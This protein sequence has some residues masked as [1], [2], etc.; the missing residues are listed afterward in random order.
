MKKFGEY[1]R[2]NTKNIINFEKILT[3]FMLPLTKEELD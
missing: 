3:F 2:E 1:L